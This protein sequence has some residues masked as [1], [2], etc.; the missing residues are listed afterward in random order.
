MRRYSPSG[1]GTILSRLRRDTRGVTAVLVGLLMVPLC[2][3]LGGAVDLGV[4]YYLKNRLGYSVDSAA[5]AVGSTVEHDVDIEQRARDFVAANYPDDAIGTVH[6]V[7]VTDVDNVITVSAKATFQTFFMGIFSL[8]EI[9]V[10]AEAEVIRAIR[11]LEVALVLDN[12]G[13]MRGGNNIGALRDASTDFVNILFGDQVTNPNLFISIVPYA[14]S[15]NPG[16]EAFGGDTTPTPPA[17]WPDPSDPWYVEFKYNPDDNGDTLADGQG[18]KGCV[19]ERTGADLLDDTPGGWEAWAW[20]PEP[21]DGDIWPDWPDVPTGTTQPDQAEVADCLDGSAAEPC[22]YDNNSNN[23]NLFNMTGSVSAGGVRY[24]VGTYQNN[25]A[26]PNLGCPGPILPLNNVKSIVLDT[27]DSL[28]AWHR[29]GTMADLGLAWGRRVLSPE[30]PFTEGEPW[31]KED[32]EK[33]IVM[34]TDGNNQYYRLPSNATNGST[35]NDWFNRDNDRVYSDYSGIGWLASD[36]PRIGTNSISTA[37][38]IVDARMATMCEEL[39]AQGIIVYTVTFGNTSSSTEE[40]Y[41]N[42]ATDPSKW[43]DSP[44]QDDLRKS[45]KAIAVELSNLRVSR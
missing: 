34:M 10:A 18:W 45:F 23:Y 12:T 3:M 42:C 13:S 14:A 9:T 19:L 40:L 37:N 17:W 36:N 24:D 8:D 27:V 25:G 43:F 32:W 33:A 11:G 5:L 15:V 21:D 39:K 35:A 16:P 1:I 29:G 41:R 6:D 20:P 30:P 28:D 38:T 2:L 26:G 7:V 44:S 22:Y 31:D 4:A